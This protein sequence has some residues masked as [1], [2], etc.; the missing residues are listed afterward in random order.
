MIWSAYWDVDKFVEEIRNF[1]LLLQNPMCR[2]WVLWIWYIE[3]C[4]IDENWCL[5]NEIDGD[6]LLEMEI[7]RC[8]MS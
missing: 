1:W 7:E 6:C 4:A 8:V 2:K 5:Q 3:Y